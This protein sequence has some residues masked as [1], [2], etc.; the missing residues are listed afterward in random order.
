[1]STAIYPGTFDPI[2]YGHLDLVQRAIK[3][4]DHLVV[5]VGHNPHKKPPLFSVEE[6]LDMIR[7]AVRGYPQV[8]VDV[9]TGLLVDH[10]LQRGVHTVIRSLRTTTEFEAELAQAEANRQLNPKLETV[11]L[12]P[13]AEFN[14]LSSTIVREI[15]Q[16]RGNLT[17]FVP[18]H[19]EE[20]LRVKFPLDVKQEGWTSGIRN[21]SPSE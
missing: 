5:A 12:M 21:E 10:A 17:A 3:F 9:F 13:S 2:T 19:V 11:F 7:H 16:F 18:P 1:M 20:R 15:A 8:E 4:F 14:Y 6:R